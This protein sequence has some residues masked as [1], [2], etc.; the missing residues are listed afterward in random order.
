MKTTA[1]ILAALLGVMICA[2]T[3]RAAGS[4]DLSLVTAA[5]QGDR[6]AVQSLLQSRAKKDVAGPEG[7]AALVWAA[8]RN[9]LA[10]ADLL[11]R[12]GANAKAANEFGA[13]PLYAAAAHVDPAMTVKLLAAGADPNIPLMSGETPL[14]EAAQRGNLAVVRALLASHANPNARE[15][16]GGQDA[17]MWALSE[18]QSAVVEELVTHG[19]DVRAGSKTGFTPLMV[20][21]QQGDGDSAGILLRA[22]AK[23]NDVQPKTGLT[24]LMIASAMANAK[25]VDVLLDN[26][27]DPN[28]ADAS[29][30][31]SLHRVVRDSDYGINLAAKDDILSI[32]KS[33]LK[34]GANPNARLVQDKEKAAEEIKNGN[35]AIEG[36]RSAVTV[37]EIILQGATPLF[38]AA[39][40]NNLDVIKT[41]VDAGADP[42]LATE[43]GTTPLMMAAGAG[44]DV[45][46]EREPQERATAVETAKFLVEHGADVNAA[47]QYGWTA[48]H[49]AAYQGLNDVIA[50][51]VSKG[52]RIDQKDEFGQTAL[53]ISLSVLTRDIGARRLQIPRRYREDTA[54][55][56]LKLGAGTLD[57][58]GVDV[59]L[60]RSGDLNLGN[61]ATQ[62]P[63]SK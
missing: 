28:I 18:R 16:N 23:P 48:L 46:R 34:H 7:T 41:L 8:T 10:M 38:L 17:L 58:T 54:Q 22:G 5:K 2:A 21:A 43:R 24:A 31:T 27:A 30:Y 25:A 50:Y 9:D 1:T 63:E 11:L 12:A 3:A 61:R 60:Q 13:T 59:I 36:K 49:A 29:G 6:A 51:L 33:L 32:V 57:S 26:G 56:L 40:V 19:A 42:L 62:V 55:L 44:T 45:Q 4:G 35:V 52:A 53:S 37:D 20:A 15:S 39:E 14:M 47:G